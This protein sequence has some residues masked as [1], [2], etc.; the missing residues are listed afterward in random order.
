[1]RDVEEDRPALDVFGARAGRLGDGETDLRAAGRGIG[2]PILE[3]LQ[4]RDVLRQCGRGDQRHDGASSSDGS[5]HLLGPRFVS[6]A[7]NIQP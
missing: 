1:M 3:L 6:S 7:H 4:E 5:V 2:R